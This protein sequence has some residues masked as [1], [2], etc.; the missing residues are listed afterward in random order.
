MAQQPGRH[1]GHREASALAKGCLRVHLGQMEKKTGC[2][3]SKPRNSASVA[4]I[5]A[6]GGFW[7]I[8]RSQSSLIHHPICLKNPP[9][10]TEDA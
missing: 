1:M 3:G 2:L 6:K 8:E 7:V 9:T 4:T 5:D 10:D